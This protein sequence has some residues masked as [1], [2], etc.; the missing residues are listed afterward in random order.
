MLY[1]INYRSFPLNLNAF[2]YK[3]YILYSNLMTKYLLKQSFWSLVIITNILMTSATLIAYFDQHSGFTLIGILFWTSLQF[4][5]TLHFYGI[6]SVGFV[7]WFMTTLYLKYKFE[8]INENI[9]IGIEFKS[10][11][12]LISSIERHQLATQLTKQFN[13]FFSYILFSMYYFATPALQILIYLTHA[14]DTGFYPRFVFAFVFSVVFRALFSSTLMCTMVSKAAHR[15]N[16]VLH[17]FI[18]SPK[19]SFQ[20]RLK[21]MAFIEKLSGP[22][23]GYYCYN[24]FPMNYYELY[25]YISIIVL[26]Y[27]LLLGLTRD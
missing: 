21:I 27:L 17:R 12:S 23:I 8:E 5:W 3:R 16:K 19:L 11:K 14:K 2:H 20:R 22:D 24:L 9:E 18:L 1:W 15:S 4:I 26:N 10:Y 25:K 7:V 6:V 13:D